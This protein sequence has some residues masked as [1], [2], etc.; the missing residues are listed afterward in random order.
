MIDRAVYEAVVE[1]C[2]LLEAGAPVAIH[3]P[4]VRR[5]ITAALADQIHT[6]WASDV[7]RK[8][9]A[10]LLNVAYSAVWYRTREG[11]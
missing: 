2:L 3:V 8:D 4:L 11:S 10:A 1:R 7:P 6:L 5:R 9:I